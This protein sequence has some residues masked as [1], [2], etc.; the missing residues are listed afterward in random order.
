MADRIV[1]VGTK[2]GKTT[3]EPNV[4][5]LCRYHRDQVVWKGT[6]TFVVDF[7]GRSPFRGGRFRGSGGRPARSGSPKKARGRLYYK[8]SVQVVGARR[9][10]PGVETEP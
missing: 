5:H 3:V 4:V 8:Y 10:D 1:M 2:N 9:K 6:R 7:G